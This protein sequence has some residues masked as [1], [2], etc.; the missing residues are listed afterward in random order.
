MTEWE[1][2]KAVIARRGAAMLVAFE[3]LFVIALLAGLANDKDPETGESLA[4]VAAVLLIVV[5]P[6][7]VALG[8]TAWILWR[9]RVWPA[10]LGRTRTARNLF[11]MGIV[12]LINLA[13][14]LQA[15]AGIMTLQIETSRSIAGFVGLIVATAC[16]LMIRN[17]WRDRWPEV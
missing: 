17:S 10:S 5:L 7:V 6:L 1:E 2:T 14:T 16:V 12:V 13:L 11:A 8:A 4:P 15:L 3:A 9:G